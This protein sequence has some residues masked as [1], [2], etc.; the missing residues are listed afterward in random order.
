MNEQTVMST[1]K[2]ELAGLSAYLTKRSAEICRD[3]D[4]TEAEHH[5]ESYAYIDADGGLLD[6]CYPDFFQGCSRPYAAIPLPWSG[7]PEELA[8][9]IAEQTWEEADED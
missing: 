2:H 8:E 6:I 9:E 5:C 7:T 1:Q 3:N 4:C